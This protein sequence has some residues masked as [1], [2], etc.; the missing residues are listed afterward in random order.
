MAYK[1]PPT[2]TLTPPPTPQPTSTGSSSTLGGAFVNGLFGLGQSVLNNH[3]ADKAATR[4][5]NRQLEFWN[6]Q[7]E[8]NSPLA[9]R[10]RLQQAGMNPNG[11]AGEVASGQQAGE[12]SSVPGNEYAQNGVLRLEGLAQ[13]L[14]IMSRIEK[15][16]AET[17][18]LTTQMTTEALQQTLLGLGIDKAEVDYIIAQYEAQGKAME[19]ENLPYFYEHTRHMYSLEESYKSAEIEHEKSLKLL[20]D[21]HTEESKE[22]AKK[23]AAETGLALIRVETE[24]SLQALNYSHSRKLDWET[25]KSMVFSGLER[26]AMNLANKLSAT[27]N[28]RAEIDKILK[29]AEKQIMVNEDGTP[30]TIAKM[31]KVLESIG[32]VFGIAIG[33]AI[34]GGKVKAAK[35]VGKGSGLIVPSSTKIG[36]DTW[37]KL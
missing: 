15:L 29:E 13:T 2:V 9:Q 23:I 11:V 37:T 12:L 8:Y 35:A 18:L 31:S 17:G 30:T 1:E 33:A 27:E 25:R 5:Y 7:N 4:Q 36:A 32:S 24:K 14:E 22:N 34:G 21:A 6:M 10:E 16:G 26:R 28:E 3:F 20:A 19:L